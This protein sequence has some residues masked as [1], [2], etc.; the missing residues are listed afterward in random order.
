MTVD[1]RSA[2]DHWVDGAPLLFLPARGFAGV[3]FCGG[4]Q[5]VGW[6]AVLT[7]VIVFYALAFTFGPFRLLLDL[8][9]PSFAMP[10]RHRAC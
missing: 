4:A 9:K 10:G 8:P 1:Y 7:L 6:S 5:P 2:A 3:L